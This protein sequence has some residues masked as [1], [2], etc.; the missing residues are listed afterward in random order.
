MLMMVSPQQAASEGLW[1][2]VAV[3]VVVVLEFFVCLRASAL[4]ISLVVSSSIFYVILA[5]AFIKCL[6]FV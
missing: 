6:I 3:V 2:V 1:L 4:P 5:E